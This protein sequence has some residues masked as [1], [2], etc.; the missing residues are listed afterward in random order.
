LPKFYP[1]TLAIVLLSA[2]FLVKADHNPSEPNI[3][4]IT[5]GD[6]PPYHSRTIANNGL[7]TQLIREVY[8]EVG[9]SV[10]FGVFPWKRALLLAHTPDSA[11]QGS[12][13]WTKT[14]EREEEFFYTNPM[15]HGC[16]MF[17][18][19]R[20]TAFDWTRPETI[21]GLTIGVIS[22]YRSNQLIQDMKDSGLGIKVDEVSEEKFGMRML[23]A[24]RVDAF[25]SHKGVGKT[26]LDQELNRID[27]KS[28]TWHP[29]PLYCDSYH[30]LFSK[31]KAGSEYLVQQFNLGLKTLRDN[32]RYQEI[33]G[34][35]EV[36]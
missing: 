28:I 20:K 19:K 9:V 18:H 22:G 21:N 2:S 13:G 24:G 7:Y 33:M 36:K 23:N 6:W 16:V 15:H 14:A 8:Q 35:P 17:F 25:V 27:S 12:S 10:E 1:L 11:W 30:L 29:K 26:I 5:W 4:R 34:E 31:Q 3:A 32:G